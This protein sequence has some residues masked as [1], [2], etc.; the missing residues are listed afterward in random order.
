MSTTDSLLLNLS[1]L[2]PIVNHWF[3]LLAAVIWIGGLAFLVMAVTPALQTGVPKQYVKP[4]ADIFYRK[5]RKVVGILLTVILVTG[6]INFH[7][8]NQMMKSQTGGL[9]IGQNPK[10]LTVFF[11]KLALVLVI[12]T[13]F[14]Y[15]VIFR[16][17][18]TGEETEEEKEEQFQEPIPFQRLA[19]WMGIFIILCA[20]AL[21]YLHF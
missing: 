16:T 13:V 4:L 15:T 17:E 19:L 6:G 2:V 10:Y 20:A 21:K 11:I 18:E 14:L 8:I 5:Y 3:H 9:G 1:Q 12:M 7:Y